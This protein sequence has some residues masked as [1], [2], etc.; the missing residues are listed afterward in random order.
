MITTSAKF[1]GAVSLLALVAA[2]AYFVATGGE[3]YGTIILAFGGVAA[4]LLGT[5]AVIVRDGDVP[6]PAEGAAVVEEPRPH[7]LPAAW[8][9]LTAVGVALTVIGLAAG[10]ALTFVGLGL[11]AIVLVEWMVQAWAERSTGDP[12]ANQGLRNRIMFPLEIPVLAV[13]GFALVVLP[14]SRVLL[15]VTAEAAA[16]LAILVAALILAIAALMAT[17]PQISSSMMSSVVVVGVVL[18]LGGGIAGAVAGEREFE[19]HGDEHHEE[20]EPAEGDVVI[21]A[22][23][24]T[25]FDDEIVTIDADTD[26]TIVFE[27]NDE[28]VQHNLHVQGVFDDDEAST[29]EII[30]GVASTTL[31]INAPPGEYNF[32]CDVHPTNMQGTLVAQELTVDEE[33]DVERDEDLRPGERAPEPEGIQEE[34]P[35]A[36]PDLEP[37]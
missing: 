10:N 29:T 5:V 9:A 14:L 31:E 36:P 17:R 12:A 3:E 28:G 1:W 32:I 7:A 4:A 23:S 22:S 2:G 30:T 21:S 8:P 35:A 27:N 37:S 15:A 25:A 34:D 19:H 26:V 16:I 18:L 33:V 24:A 20:E 11:L 6:P 13:I